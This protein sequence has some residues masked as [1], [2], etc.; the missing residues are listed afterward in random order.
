MRRAICLIGL[1]LAVGCGGTAP[2]DPEEVYEAALR[3]RLPAKGDGDGIFVSVEGKDPSEELMGRLQKQWPA[4]RPASETP[5]RDYH[6][7]SVGELEW[8]WGG[9]NVRV[10]SSNGIDGHIER[11]RMVWKNGQWEA[12]SSKTEAIS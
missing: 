1:C 9:A 6:V 7:I 12:E 3:A 4:L 11:V 2:R 10:G 8:V 5:K